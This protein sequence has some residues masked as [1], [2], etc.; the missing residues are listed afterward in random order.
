MMNI[1]HKI[2]KASLVISLI[3]SITSCQKNDPPK[4]S[5]NQI[6]TSKSQANS[7]KSKNEE[8]NF[9]WDIKNLSFFNLPNLTTRSVPI[10]PNID[11]QNILGTTFLPN[12]ISEI[13]NK[14]NSNKFISD[15]YILGIKN[16]EVWKCDTYSDIGDQVSY[17]VTHSI[18]GKLKEKINSDFYSDFLVELNRDT[19]DFD[20]F[21]SIKIQFDGLPSKELQQNSYSVLKDILGEKLATILAFGKDLDG[22]D[23]TKKEKLK[24]DSEMAEVVSSEDGLTTYTLYRNFHIGSYIQNITYY[25][26]VNEKNYKN[27]FEYFH[28]DYESIYNSMDYKISDL[29]SPS[30]GNTDLDNFSNFIS[31]IL[32]FGGTETYAR[33]VIDDINLTN[34]VAD[35]G[36]KVNKIRFK[37]TKACSDVAYIVA[38]RY[39]LDFEVTKI[40]DEIQSFNYSI[41]GD[42]G[43]YGDDESKID[44]YFPLLVDAMKNKL[45]ASIN[46]LDLSEFDYSTFENGRKSSS[47]NITMF[48]KKVPAKI[49]MTIGE[50]MMDAF[51]GKFEFVAK[52]KKE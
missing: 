31:S 13:K 20:N 17:N 12:D 4:T 27:K 48:D 15:T 36:I 11:I 38:P 25:V 33:T 9:E 28:G 50:N 37:V 22:L 49:S 8:D 6:S 43:Y 34:F 44:E 30:A 7:E 26:G 51:A 14:L 32:K 42:A 2:V 41:E 3:F 29:L 1:L 46:G 47:I 35:D 24:Y 19:N 52:Y 10:A 5:N 39:S 16:K 40:N 21:S 18:E 23:E 45:N